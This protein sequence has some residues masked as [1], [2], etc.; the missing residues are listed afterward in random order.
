MVVRKRIPAIARSET[1]IDVD[2]SDQSRPPPASL[3]AVVTVRAPGPI[4]VV[5][6]PATVVIGSPAPW[7]IAYPCPAIR[8]QPLPATI[9]IRSPV[10]VA[11]D[12]ACARSPNP[13]IVICINP[14]AVR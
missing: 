13:A 1:E 5:V 7:L 8:W 9:A 3:R 11:A 6:N 4:V 14:V 12:D 10:C 2:E